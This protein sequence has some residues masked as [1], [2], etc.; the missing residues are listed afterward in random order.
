M[1]GASGNLNCPGFLGSPFWRPF[2]VPGRG[3]HE[4]Y[5]TLS[6]PSLTVCNS[7]CHLHQKILHRHQQPPKPI[8][9]ETD[10][11]TPLPSTATATPTPPPTPTNCPPP[12]GWVAYVVQPGDTLAILSTRYR[13]SSTTLKQANCL[14]KSELKAG[15]I[16]YVPP[17]P[18]Q[19]RIPCGPPRG[20][21]AFIVQPG[22]TLYRLSQ[23]YG[24]TVADLQ[25]ANC[26]GSTTLLQVGKTIYVPPWAPHT[27]TPVFPGGDTPTY[28]PTDTL[29]NFTP[30]DTPTETSTEVPPN[31]ETPLPSETPASN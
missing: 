9:T 12:S 16:I 6:R 25:R 7:L 22:D 20:W 18:T 29:S 30:P 24:I 21:I 26:M 14:L 23:A 3:K 1:A 13:I 11:P 27:P 17:L 31:T 10:S 28:V 8:A 19:T 5:N 2:V 15:S 4:Q